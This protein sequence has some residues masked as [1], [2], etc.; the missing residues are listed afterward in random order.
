MSDEKRGNSGGIA[1]YATAGS[2]LRHRKWLN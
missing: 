1:N 2:I